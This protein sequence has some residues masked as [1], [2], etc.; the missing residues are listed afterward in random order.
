MD[1]ARGNPI[2]AQLLAAPPYFFS[3][4]PALALAYVS[5][6]YIIRA[7]ILWVQ[8]CLSIAGLSMVSNPSSLVPYSLF[9]V[10]CSLFTI[11]NRTTELMT[12]HLFSTDCIW[13]W[14][15]G[16][17]RWRI[18]WTRRRQ[19]QRGFSV[20][21]VNAAITHDFWAVN[22][23]GRLG[24]MQNNVVGQTKR[25]FTSALVIG[26][27]GIGGIIASVSFRTKDLPYYR[28]GCK[29]TL[30]LLLWSSKPFSL[31]YRR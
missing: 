31:V 8:A 7:P 27:G 13:Y 29:F 17:I 19:R 21:W 1:F 4:W 11:S 24:Y 14:Q 10:H 28:P 30:H 6:K 5:D 15:C 2:N 12:L 3:V 23:N 18:P 26:F 22:N 25:A 9:P 20:R 16:S